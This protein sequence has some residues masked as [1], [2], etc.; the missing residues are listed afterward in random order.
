MCIDDEII[1][2]NGYQLKNDFNNWLHYYSEAKQV[3]LTL[4]SNGQIKQVSVKQDR[5]KSY[6]PLYKI[7]QL[8]AVD[9]QQKVNFT[10]W[11]KNN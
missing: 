10:E 3:E 9:G 2:V 8:K 6:F 11:V 1:A 4:I 5:D 7:G